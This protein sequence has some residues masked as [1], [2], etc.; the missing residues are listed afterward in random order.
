[1]SL[2]LKMLNYP[3]PVENYP[4][5]HIQMLWVSLS[6]LKC[7]SGWQSA[8]SILPIN[9]GITLQILQ[10]LYCGKHIHSRQLLYQKCSFLPSEPDE[11]VII[12]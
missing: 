8:G 1:M 10:K 6:L 7:A 5:R 12:Y 4:D 9:L 11:T 3:N 2:I